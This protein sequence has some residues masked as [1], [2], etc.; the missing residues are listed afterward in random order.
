[1]GACIRREVAAAVMIDRLSA[2]DDAAFEAQALCRAALTFTASFTEELV[3]VNGVRGLHPVP[4]S[5]WNCN[6]HLT[7]SGSK[8]IDVV[9]ECSGP[10]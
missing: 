10:R 3:C 8:A 7:N 4:H 1:M 5:P 6:V 9:R 2:A